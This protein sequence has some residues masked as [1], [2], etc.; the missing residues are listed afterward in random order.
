MVVIFNQMVGGIQNNGKGEKM[1]T[2]EMEEIIKACQKV[3][4]RQQ[5][6]I[7]ALR[8]LLDNINK[9]HLVSWE[10]FFGG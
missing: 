2:K 4:Q 1:D 8:D 10:D 5:K 6:E 7:K 3:M 9:E